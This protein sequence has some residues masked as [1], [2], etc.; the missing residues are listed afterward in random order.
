MSLKSAIFA[1][2]FLSAAVFLPDIFAED[3]PA[4]VTNIQK[5]QE[6]KSNLIWPR[7]F[8]E[9]G[10]TVVLF[11]PQIDSWKDNLKI[12]FRVALAVSQK[13]S[14]ILNYGVM[15]VQADTFVDREAR[16]VLISNMEFAVRF[17]GMADAKADVFKKLVKDLVPKM[18]CL[19]VP[20]E[21][22]LSK[23]PENSKVPEVKLNLEPPPIFYSEEP[24]I[25]VTFIGQPIFKDVAGTK[26][27]FAVNT[28]WTVLNDT[29]D[30]KYY[31]LN[32]SF[33][34]VSPDPL[35]GPW[36]FSGSLPAEFSSL[37]KDSAWDDVRKMIPGNSN[38]KL[39]K[40]FT[41]TVPSELIVMKGPAEFTSVP[42]TKLMYATNPLTPLFLD[43]NDKNYYFLVAGRWFRAADLNGPW[44]A[45]STSLPAEFAKIKS[46]SPVGFVLASVPGTQEAKD[47]VLLASVPHKATVKISE[48]TVK[49]IYDGEPKF[50][51]IPGTT[52]T[53]A[54]NTQFQVVKANGLYYCCYQGIWFQ[55]LNSTGPWTVCRKVD[56]M[57]Y[58]IPPECPLYNTTYVYVYDSTPE[59]AVVGYTS[60]YSGSF[61]SSSTKTLMFG[62]AMITMAA[63]SANNSDSSFCFCSYG[64]GAHYSYA[65][66]NYYRPC[67]PHYGPY[68]GAGWCGFYNP[69]T[70]AW[71]RSGYV[72]GS[73][74]A[75]WGTQ[76]YNPFTD[77]Y[78]AHAGGKNGYD[79]WGRSVV[80][81]DGNWAE[82][83]H[84]TGPNGV[85]RGWAENS[86]GKW[87]AGEH[88]GDSTL[89][90]ASNG[91]IY[92]GH[93]G[94]LYRK[95][96][97]QWQKYDGNGNWGDANWKSDRDGEK[98]DNW[99]GNDWKDRWENSKRDGEG[100]P[101]H[102]ILDGLNR[103]SRDRD[104]G[105]D[106]SKARHAA[107]MIFLHKR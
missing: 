2:V 30:S 13:G 64:C 6:G 16:T 59:T 19:D 49:V 82:A 17:P 102:R 12:Q 53:Y 58:T 72:Y 67:Y 36:T 20:L 93:D 77:R 106:R 78:Y 76:A 103:D 87:I 51:E 38:E 83:G 81:H 56:P 24:A 31:L 45:A 9:G 74:W 61:N 80:T 18:K 27:K 84:F 98:G 5:I 73:D 14:E 23:M 96:D 65:W 22:L 66:G 48:T 75:R 11:Q 91:D 44:K 88:K 52:M 90:K 94:N 68:G 46:D 62:A 29:V 71:G 33:W 50:I 63:V 8:E 43:M 97:G 104:A 15:A 99:K 85:T 3:N 86:S 79:S 47:A 105:A 54:V 60:G 70:G 100:G 37:P 107:S 57:I 21:N 32:D 89:A 26:L 35:K 40:V 95:E 28:N 25:L 101:G 7:A 1:T 34:L 69:S 55:S 10:N 42:G 92:A 39:P 41:G 4:G